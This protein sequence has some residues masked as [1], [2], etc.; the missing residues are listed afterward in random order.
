MSISPISNLVIQNALVASKIA[1]KIDRQLS[2]HG[3][4][5]TEFLI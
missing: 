4:S 1:R 2:I 3:I 5:F